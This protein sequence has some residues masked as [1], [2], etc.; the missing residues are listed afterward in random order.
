MTY[1]KYHT[2]IKTSFAL[3]IHNQILPASFIDSLAPSTVSGW[4]HLNPEQFVGYQFAN[5]I[6]S[7]LD[8]V[9]DVR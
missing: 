3:N 9:R 8:D 2:A 6:E 5:Q 7:N 1:N 4:K